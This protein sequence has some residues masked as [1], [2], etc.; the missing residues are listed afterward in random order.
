[1]EAGRVWLAVKSE[2]G[3]QWIVKGRQEGS[4]YGG[5][6]EAR[7]VVDWGRGEEEA[8]EK[9]RARGGEK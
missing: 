3:R 2:R 1:M 9:G 4:G 7:V 5:E 8:K 6:V